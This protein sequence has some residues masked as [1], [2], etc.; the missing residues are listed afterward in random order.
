MSAITAWSDVR[1]NTLPQDLSWS[2]IGSRL[3][4]KECG[5]A[6]SVHIVPNWH[7]ISRAPAKEIGNNAPQIILGSQ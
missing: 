3:V 4:C 6:G 7:D 1:L 5:V 2:K